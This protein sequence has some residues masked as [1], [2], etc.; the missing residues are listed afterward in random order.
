MIRIV[1]ATT[2]PHGLPMPPSSTIETRI[3]ESPKVK[4]VGA[5]NPS[6]MA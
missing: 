2:S 5:I 1:V 4:L 3:S 6:I